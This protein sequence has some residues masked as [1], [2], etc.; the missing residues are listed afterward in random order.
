MSADNKG[1]KMPPAEKVKINKF[2]C[3]LKRKYVIVLIVS[4]FVAVLVSTLLFFVRKS[5][6]RKYE[7]TQGMPCSAHPL[8]KAGL[9]GEVIRSWSYYNTNKSELV[10]YSKS[11]YKPRYKKHSWAPITNLNSSKYKTLDFFTTELPPKPAVSSSVTLYFQR[12]AKVYILVPGT[13]SSLSPAFLPGWQSEDWV[14]M[15]SGRQN[16]TSV[17]GIVSQWHTLLPLNAH[18]F[19]KVGEIVSLP[20][21]DWILKN[22]KGIE[23]NGKYATLIAESDGSPTTIPPIKIPGIGKG[24]DIAGM[25]C[26]VELHSSWVTLADDKKDADL[27]EF[28]F[29][30]YHPIWDPCFWCAFDH[31]HGSDSITSMSYRPKLNYVAYKNGRQNESHIGFKSLVLDVGRYL[32]HFGLH[33]QLSSTRRFFTRFHTVVIVAVEKRSH[34]LMLELS[35]K[36]DFGFNSARLSGGQPMPLTDADKKISD[37]MEGSNATAFGTRIVNVINPM[38]LD[39]RFMYREFETRMRGLY[40]EWKTSPMCSTVKRQEEPTV[41]FKD[42]SMA[43]RTAN[44][45]ESIS[46]VQLFKVINGEKVLNKNIIREFHAINWQLGDKHCYFEGRKPSSGYFYTDV[47]G[48]NVMDGP[49]INAVRQY[50]KPG[51][52]LKISGTFM[53]ADNWQRIMKRKRKGATADSGNA[54]DWEKN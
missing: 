53:P 32:V 37:S 10:H 3:A 18:A 31:E 14:K 25:R 45:N 44:Y 50:I 54:I 26:P 17:F 51:F 21:H 39:K 48:K 35:Y 11:F 22:V 34:Q 36:A 12:P 46:E 9:R 27:A 42:P 7:K 23:T 19:S 28:L 43:L 47:Y 30:T 20:H 41:D 1:A 52:N 49:G 8:N 33:S 15:V 38:G 24:I 4:I 40:E 2:G 29:S 5:E 13:N 16:R 6:R